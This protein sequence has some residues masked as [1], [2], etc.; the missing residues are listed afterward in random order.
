MSCRRGTPCNALVGPSHHI[1]HITLHPVNHTREQ[2]GGRQPVAFFVIVGFVLPQRL[3]SIVG[4]PV[5]GWYAEAWL[6]SKKQLIV[7]CVS[8]GK[9]NGENSHKS[10]ITVEIETKKFDVVIEYHLVASNAHF[11][12]SW[13][14]RIIHR[15]II[16][17]L[18]CDRPVGRN[19]DRT[20]P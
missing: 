11:D 1:Y 7:C 8:F 9:K 4:I 3:C 20:S 12:R 16:F 13:F 19:I 15:L 14:F 6:T 18:K 5:H 2:C 17:V 10:S